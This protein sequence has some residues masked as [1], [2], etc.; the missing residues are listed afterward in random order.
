MDWSTGMARLDP[1]EH[2]LL[3][4]MLTSHAYREKLAADR[5]RYALTLMPTSES[6][7]Y[8]S[9]VIAEEEE[10]YAGCLSVASE[11]GIELESLVASRLSRPPDGIPVFNDWLDVL[12]AHTFNDRAGYH[13][14]LGLI[15][16]K[17]TSYAKLAKE[18]VEEEERHGNSGAASLIEFYGSDI[19]SEGRRRQLLKHLDAAVWC[20]GRPNTKRDTDAVR[21]GLKTRSSEDSLKEFCEYADRVLM[22]I[23]E[24]RLVP[25]INRYQN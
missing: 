24:A 1:Y 17:I 3:S 22:R 23:G 20:L 10:H 21:L 8:W 14:L 5:F 15:G 4:N 19:N 6:G 9:S 16:S 7:N 25:I 11:I 18:I 2:R 12:L 13:V